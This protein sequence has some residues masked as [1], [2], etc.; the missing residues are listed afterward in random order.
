MR[1]LQLYLNIWKFN[2]TKIE[3]NEAINGNRV[4]DTC[5]IN[6]FNARTFDNNFTRVTRNKFIIFLL[7]QRRSNDVMSKYFFRWSCLVQLST[8]LFLHHRSCNLFHGVS[9]LTYVA[10]N[11][12][13]SSMSRIMQMLLFTATACSASAGYDV[14]PWNIKVSEGRCD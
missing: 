11:I 6:F 9:F 8:L 4:K 3:R 2:L 1:V 14:R 13:A 12:S 10:R 5:C 7:V